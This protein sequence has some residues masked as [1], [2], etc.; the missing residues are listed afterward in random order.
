MIVGEVGGGAH[1]EG[2]GEAA[3]APLRLQTK[4]VYKAK[5]NVKTNNPPNQQGP[6]ETVLSIYKLSISPEC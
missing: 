3:G 2:V 1:D 4:R 6:R 5:D